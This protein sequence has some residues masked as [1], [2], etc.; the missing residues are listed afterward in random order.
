MK[1]ATDDSGLMIEA[2][3]NAPKKALCPYCKG[4]VTLRSR[5]KSFQSGETTYYWRHQ[6]Y[7]NPGCLARF[8]AVNYERRDYK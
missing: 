3:A 7:A 4:I 6:D 1:I 8:K 2:E 5:R